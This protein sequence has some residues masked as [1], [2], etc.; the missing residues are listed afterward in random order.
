MGGLAGIG[1]GDAHIVINDSAGGADGLGTMG[2]IGM[3]MGLGG[4]MA[5]ED[6]IVSLEIENND[7][8]AMGAT[9]GAPGAIPA[10]N[11][12]DVTLGLDGDLSMS[13]TEDGSRRASR[14]EHV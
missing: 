12:G 13:E 11:M 6:R 14:G 8:F 4:G 2:D 1:H 7:D 5:G 3:N 10:A 9:P